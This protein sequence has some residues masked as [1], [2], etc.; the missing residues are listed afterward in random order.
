MHATIAAL[1][2]QCL[3]L[4]LCT[5]KKALGVFETT[6]MIW[7]LALA[8]FQDKAVIRDR[9]HHQLKAVQSGYMSKCRIL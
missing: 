8:H 4:I 5:V 3:L 9:L 1:L 7:Y 6:K 2:V